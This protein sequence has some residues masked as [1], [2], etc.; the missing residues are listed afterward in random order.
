M[1]VVR[2]SPAAGQ[3]SLEY[4]A[5]ITLVAAVLVSAG[6]AVGAPSL[7]GAVAQTVRLGVCIVATDYCRSGDAEG[8]QL[9]A[10][11]L[12][13]QVQGEDNTFTVGFF[14]FGEDAAWTAAVGSDG[15]VSIAFGAGGGAGLVAG[16]GVDSPT[17]RMDVE[18]EA[19]AGFRLQNATGWQFADAASAQRFLDGLPGSARATPPAWRSAE[20]GLEAALQVALRGA[21]VE[22]GGVEASGRVGG[23][24]RKGPGESVTVYNELVLEGP[25]AKLLGSG[26]AGRGTARL[27]VEALY[28]GGRPIQ[29]AFRALEPHGE[30]VTE[31]LERLDLRSPGNRM[32]AEPFLGV[33]APWPQDYSTAVHRALDWIATEG[34][35]E[36]ATY[37]VADDSRSLGFVVKAGQELG[38]THTSTYVKQRLEQ[39]SAKVPG[40]PFRDRFDC[41]DQLR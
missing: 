16:V 5:V 3:A 30:R 7:A 31:T 34:T 33:K 12:G 2:Q 24:V 36:R 22:A 28:V 10:C 35:I 38:F 18:A 1:R 14:R 20:T 23:G 11:A 25:D 21:G 8:D 15:S 39:A 37:R 27:M 40:A 26:V 9:P 13:R 41:T 4:V 29:L 17:L 6:P 32:I 19:S